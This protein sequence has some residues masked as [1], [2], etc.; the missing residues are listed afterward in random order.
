[1]CFFLI[2]KW[3][4]RLLAG[5]HFI[6]VKVFFILFLLLTVCLCLQFFLFRSNKEWFLCPRCLKAKYVFFFFCL[7]SVPLSA[8]SS[9]SHF[10]SLN[11]LTFPDN[12]VSFKATAAILLNI[13]YLTA[14]FLSPVSR[15]EEGG[16]KEPPDQKG[17]MW[18]TMFST[19]V[20]QTY[21]LM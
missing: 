19:A 9:H 18:F 13:F 10:H 15:R 14:E 3:C 1:M 7:L 5:A 6:C 11:L 17:F 21:M 4:E 2:G 8:E 12:T 16:F 20:A